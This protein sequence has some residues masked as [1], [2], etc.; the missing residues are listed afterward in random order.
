[1]GKQQKLPSL[2]KLMELVNDGIDDNSD[3]DED[4]DIDWEDGDE[5]F[6]DD[7]GEEQHADAVEQTLAAIA[8]SGGLQGGHIEINLESKKMT[9]NHLQWTKILV[10]AYKRLFDLLRLAT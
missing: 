1:M 4:D 7:V 6:D 9:R 2:K 8:S 3:E 10:D 5:E